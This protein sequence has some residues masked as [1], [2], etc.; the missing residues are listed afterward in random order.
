MTRLPAS[1]CSASINVTLPSL[2]LHG[3]RQHSNIGSTAAP[4]TA[5]PPPSPG[6]ITGAGERAYICRHHPDA[7]FRCY[8]Y[9]RLCRIDLTLEAGNNANGVQA[10]AN[11]LTQRQAA[12]SLSVGS[13]GLTLISGSVSGARPNLDLTSGITFQSGSN[14]TSSFNLQ[15]F[16]NVTLPNLTTTGTG[17][18]F[19]SVGSSGTRH[20]HHHVRRP[21]STR[22]GSVFIFAG[23]TLTQNSGAT[24]TTG[25]A[26]CLLTLDAGG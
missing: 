18:V 21:P 16:N 25:S 7:E 11:L 24:I 10:P 15:G 13:G 17:A 2:H 5:A 1:I 4:T 20:W 3:R 12:G 9:H 8:H 26:G 22:A 23:T 6:V 14:T 19:C